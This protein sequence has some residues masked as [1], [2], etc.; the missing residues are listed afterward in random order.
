MKRGIPPFMKAVHRNR[1]GTFHRHKFRGEAAAA[2]WRTKTGWLITLAGGDWLR[3]SWWS[4][5]MSSAE[6]LATRR[7]ATSSEEN[8]FKPIVG[9]AE[10]E[11]PGFD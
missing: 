3:R 9:R 6:T 1:V 2:K 11:L 7:N 5:I 8:L 4:H 10:T